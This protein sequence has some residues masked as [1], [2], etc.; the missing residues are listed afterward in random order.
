MSGMDKI[1][2][3]H[4]SWMNLYRSIPADLAIEPDSDLV[5]QAGAR[6]MDVNETLKEKGSSPVRMHNTQ[7]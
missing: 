6:W 7:D 5:C 2:E 1:L 4:G 3:I